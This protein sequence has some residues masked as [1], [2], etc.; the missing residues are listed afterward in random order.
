[1]KE[2]SESMLFRHQF[3]LIDISCSTP[4]S[5]LYLK[6]IGN[7]HPV[8]IQKTLKNFLSYAGSGVYAGEDKP[9]DSIEKSSYGGRLGLL[10][11]VFEGHLMYYSGYDHSPSYETFRHDN[12][13]Y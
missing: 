1:M 6:R 7:S 8:L 9:E 2:K 4:F 13:K 10:F 5:I 11:P 12:K 3:S